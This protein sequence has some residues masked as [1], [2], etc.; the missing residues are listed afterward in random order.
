MQRFEFPVIIEKDRES[1]L[2]VAFVPSLPGC[3][4]QAESLDELEQNVREVVE[5]CLEEAIARGE[6]DFPVFYGIHTVAVEM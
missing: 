5:L 4:T 2:Y 3:H 6:N 1:G